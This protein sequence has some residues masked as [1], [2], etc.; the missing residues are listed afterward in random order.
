MTLDTFSAVETHYN[1]TKPVV[2][3][4]HTKEDDI[5]PLGRRTRKHE[6]IEKRS[7]TEYV[8][9]DHWLH[10]GLSSDKKTI[11]EER[12]PITWQK[13]IWKGEET[14][15]VTVRGATADFDTTRHNFLRSYL[16]WGL[17]WDVRSSG[18]HSV[19]VTS[20]IDGF[21]DV[22]FVLRTGRRT[23]S[24]HMPHPR[25]A[26]GSYVFKTAHNRHVKVQK[27]VETDYLLRFTRTDGVGVAWQC[28]TPEWPITRS[29]VNKDRK[30]ALR[31]HNDKFWEWMCSIGPMLHTNWDHLTNLEQEVQ[32]YIKENN[33]GKLSAA[34]NTMSYN[35]WPRFPQTLALEIVK[36]YNHPLRIHLATSFLARNDIKSLTNKVDSSR[37]RSVYNKWFN[38]QLGLMEEETK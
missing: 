16:P 26:K 30:A 28:T 8:F 29:H 35:F 10:A 4:H 32:G 17:L 20:S 7:D 33:G 34:R 15:V 23:T 5:R 9:H 31:E 19:I 12:P 11:H 6:R 18:R 14:E 37:F 21:A 1:N 27:F 38:K 25:E 3:K 13:L 2:S 22:P 24:H 36:D